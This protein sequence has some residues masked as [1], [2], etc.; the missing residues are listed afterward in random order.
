[1]KRFLFH[2]LFLASVCC[3]GMHSCSESECPITTLSLARFDFLD[4]KTHV[5]ITFTNGTTITGIS[6]VEGEVL[7]DTLFN[8][9]QSSMSL[10][11]SYTHSTTYVM[12][13]TETLRD[14]IEVTHKN[15]PFVSD[16][17]CG[18]MM[19]YQVEGLRYTTNALDSVVLINPEIT[20][21]E[22]KNFNIYYRAAESE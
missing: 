3:I 16:I 1:M 11:L 5:P 14:T 13:Y 18:T 9:A 6:V 8:L 4:S 22:R 10:P 2:L 7:E 15:I 12:H 17:E 21:E 19:F 20:N